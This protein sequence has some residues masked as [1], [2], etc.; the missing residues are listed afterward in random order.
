MYTAILFFSLALFLRGNALPEGGKKRKNVRKS[1]ALTDQLL[2]SA[3]KNISTPEPDTK[4]GLKM[5]TTICRHNVPWQSTNISFPSSEWWG[6]LAAVREKKQNN[7]KVWLC[8]ELFLRQEKKNQQMR[9]NKKK[10]LRP[11]SLHE[12]LACLP[13]NI[14]HPKKLR[15]NLPSLVRDLDKLLLSEAIQ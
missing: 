6:G 1:R 13:K 12:T 5:L 14:P 15:H 3:H 2:H 4:S 11:G 8:T 7:T 10:V 9:K